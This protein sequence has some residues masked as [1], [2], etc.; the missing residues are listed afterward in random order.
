MGMYLHHLFKHYILSY[1][2]PYNKLV[3]IR[4]IKFGKYK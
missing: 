2:I 4:E 3:N 1:P